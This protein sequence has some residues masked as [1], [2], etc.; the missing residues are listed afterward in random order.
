M[1]ERLSTDIEWFVVMHCNS[2]DRSVPINSSLL[3]KILKYLVT[4]LYVSNNPRFLKNI[5]GS[6]LN[7]LTDLS[8]IWGLFISTAIFTGSECF[9]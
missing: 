7:K 3:L 8:R 1:V 2:D 6:F 5:L 9:W 4:F